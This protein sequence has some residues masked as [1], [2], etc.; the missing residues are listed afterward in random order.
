MT[1]EFVAVKPDFSKVST[2]GHI[3]RNGRNSKT[4]NVIYIVDHDGKMSD[5]IRIGELLLASPHILVEELMD[6]RFVAL[7]AMDDQVTAV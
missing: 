5:D 1:P 6:Y 3:R 4:L 7:N 2:F